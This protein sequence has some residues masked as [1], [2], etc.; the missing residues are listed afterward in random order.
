MM[1]TVRKL[2]HIDGDLG[3]VETTPNSNLSFGPHLKG[4]HE[5]DIVIIGA[6]Y[7]GISTAIRLAEINPDTRIAI[8]DAL[9]VGE[10]ASGR[11]AGFLIDLPTTQVQQHAQNDH[12]VRQKSVR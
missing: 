12:S 4:D 7:T 5:F 10:G 6:G 11:N 2:P 3:W 8:I 1:H 9:R